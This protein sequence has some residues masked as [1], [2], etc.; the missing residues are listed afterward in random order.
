M[1][2]G[3]VQAAITRPFADE[4]RALK[5]NS[6]LLRQIAEMTGG[7]VLPADPRDAEPLATRRTEDARGD[8]AHL[9]DPRDR[10]ASALPRRCRDRRVRIDPGA[11][12]RW[13]LGLFGASKIKQG[14][15]IDTLQ[16]ARAKA[17]QRMGDAERPQGGMSGRSKRRIDGGRGPQVRGRAGAGAG[18]GPSP[19]TAVKASDPPIA[20]PKPDASKPGPSRVGRA[21]HVRA[22][23][24]KSAAHA[25]QEIEAKSKPSDDKERG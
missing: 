15:R 16:A 10:L 11:I 3:T 12:A 5:D 18:T 7:Q 19:L 2:E 25:G 24:A 22:D 1:T 21:G 6:P 8:D 4:F 13:M 20:R 9:D 23:E 17:R 14:A